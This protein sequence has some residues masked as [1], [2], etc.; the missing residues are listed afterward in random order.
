MTRKHCS[1]NHRRL[2][3]LATET[4]LTLIDAYTQ[5][6][7]GRAYADLTHLRLLLVLSHPHYY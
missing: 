1:S 5:Q 7:P 3:P 4:V 2:L 6:G